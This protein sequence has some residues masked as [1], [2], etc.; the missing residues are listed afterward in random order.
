MNLDNVLRAVEDAAPVDA[1]EAVT[2]GIGVDLGALWV[3]F[4]VADMSGRALVRLAHDVPF[5][6][7]PGRRQHDED[8][9]TVLPFDGGPREQA[10]RSQRVQVR[11]SG[12]D[13]V[14]MAPVTQR[15]EAIGLLEVCLPVEPDDDA[16][17]EISRAAHA[18]AFVVIAARRHTDLFEW[19]QRTTPFTLAA[20]I[21]RRL[22]PSSFTCEAGS[23]TLSAWLEPAASIGG[24]TFDYSLARNLLHLSI[25]DAV[26]HGVHSALTATLCVGSLRHTR[27]RGHTLVDQARAANSALIENPPGGFTFAT[28]L[29]G[30]LD[31]RTG[32][33]A[34]V[35][36]GHPTP[37][38]VRDGTVQ[39]LA[40][41]VDPPFG[42]L[43]HGTYRTTD[44]PLRP[45]DRLIL[46][47]DGMLERGAA[48]LDLPARLPG[49]T[50]LHPREVVRVLGDAILDVAGPALPDDACLLVLDWHGDHG[51]NRSTTAGADPHRAS[52]L[53]YP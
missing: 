12:N 46:L 7:R 1:V 10:L 16:L 32:V 43:R 35:N 33:L 50:D 38:L 53:P 17:A 26:G 20:E 47:T 9:A 48:H 22:L 31:L 2:R 51:D 25:T 39:P 21:Q 40:L 44:V 24:D 37:F 41:P 52:A 27:R 28:G 19:G 8:V 49:L 42:V 34:M 3:S 45:D 5:G 11:R 23:F 13:H 4:L 29:L 6:D 30:R 15:G 36:A 18:L 14:V